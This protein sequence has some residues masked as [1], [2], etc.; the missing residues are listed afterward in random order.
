MTVRHL[1]TAAGGNGTAIE[2]VNEPLTRQDYE[3]RGTVLCDDFEP[4]GAEQAGFLVLND[5]HFEMAGGEFCGNA[6]RSAAVLLYQEN[7]EGDQSF[8]VSGFEGRVNATIKPLTTTSFF[9]EAVFPGMRLKTKQ[10]ALEDGTPASIVDLGGIVHVVVEGKF[11]S[12]PDVYGTAHRK[13]VSQFSLAD[14]DAVGVVWYQKSADAIVMHPVVWVRAV[15]T[16]YYESSCGSGTI[17]VGGVTGASSIVQPSG[18]PIQATITEDQVILAS[19]ME[20]VK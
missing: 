19:E 1:V 4:H 16:F 12:D 7:R 9:V 18:L 14:R 2:I 3:S 5:K 15:D 20:I 10:V 8:T 6:T 17:A 11:P 13:I